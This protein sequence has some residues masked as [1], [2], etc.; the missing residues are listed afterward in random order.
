[1]HTACLFWMRFCKIHHAPS[2]RRLLFLHLGSPL[3]QLHPH[4]AS[5]NCERKHARSKC[6]VSVFW[7][8]HLT[9]KGVDILRLFFS[10]SFVF[11]LFCGSCRCRSL[12][13]SSKSGEGN[14]TSTDVFPSCSTLSFRVVFVIYC[15]IVIYSAMLL[16]RLALIDSWHLFFRS[17]RK[18]KLKQPQAPPRIRK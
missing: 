9:K 7:A 5:E 13:V 17:T 3:D 11:A 4:P 18:Q 1:M 10:I 8:H 16:G 6:A 12:P 15:D 14:S 2:P